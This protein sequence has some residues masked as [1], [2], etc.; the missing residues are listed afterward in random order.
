MKRLCMGIY[1]I[2]A[3][4]LGCSTMARAQMP[5]D[6]AEKIA[7]MGRVIELENTG[8]IYEPLH[9]KEPY[10]GLKVVRD[11]KYGTHPRQVVDIFTPE[12]GAAARP[13]LM[14]VHGGGYVAG[15]KRLPG[16]AF[17]DNIMVFAARHGMV[18]V[19]VEY[20]LAPEFPWPA[21][22][23]DLAAALR[24]VADKAAD[25]GADP[26]R[27][28][29]MGHS[30]GANHVAAYVSHPEFH[31]P[32]GSGLAGALL[33]SGIYEI[34]TQDLDAALASILAYFGADQSRYAERAA[35]PGLVTTT[36][37]FMMWSAELDPPNLAEQFVALKEAMCRSQRGCVRSLVLPHHSHTSEMFAIGTADTLLSDQIL[38]FIKTAK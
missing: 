19:N 27:I 29:L 10:A 26:D 14:F 37:P 24:L 8:K 38:E 3:I 12:S 2:A 22:N 31:G 5:P 18:G 33:S 16:T 34:K 35:L 21:G 13:V 36:I 4:L 1:A 7:A 23:E 17:F 11:V 25:F 28:Y 15:N 20:R 6:I 9:E 32:K 30:A